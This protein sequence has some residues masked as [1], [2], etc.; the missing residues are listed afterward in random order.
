MKKMAV[1][2]VLACA[3]AFVAV[4]AR[5]TVHV[6][7]FVQRMIAVATPWIAGSAVAMFVLWILLCCCQNGM[8]AR[9]MAKFNRL[10]PFGRFAALAAVLLCTM[11]GGSK[12]RGHGTNATSLHGG[13]ETWV[14]EPGGLRSLPQIEGYVYSGTNDVSSVTNLCFIDLV[15]PS[16]S[17]VAFSVAW[18][19]SWSLPESSL[20]LYAR[21]DLDMGSWERLTAVQVPDGVN[22]VDVEVPLY[23]LPEGGTNR[24]FFTLGTFNDSD[25]DGIPDSDE[26]LMYGTNPNSS[27][28]DGDWML[29]KDE[30][31][32]GSNPC[33]ND[34]DGDGIKD[35]EEVGWI[36]VDPFPDPMDTVNVLTNLT[37]AFL[38]NTQS[39]VDVALTFPCSIS[40]ETFQRMT[41]DP[42]GLIHL[43]GTGGTPNLAARPYNQNINTAS[44]PSN[45]FT[46]AA[47]WAR[48]SL[49]TNEPASSIKI[50]S[51]MLGMCVEFMN[52]RLADAPSPDDN[53]VSFL[54]YLPDQWFPRF[55][56][57][58]ALVGD[59]ADGRN[60]SVGA[61][62]RRGA[63]RRSFCYWQAGRMVDGMMMY[64]EPGYGTDPLVA[65][66][67]SD[68]IDDGEELAL[69]TRPDQPD[70]DGDGMN[71]G[72][73][74]S[75]G[76]DPCTHN[77]ETPRTDDDGTADPDGDGL[78]NAEECEWDT[79]PRGTDANGDGT[80][81][82]YDTDG[83]GV[84]D[85]AEVGQSSDPADAT[86]LGA[87]NSR[88]AVPFYFGD[89]SGSHSEKY[90]LDVKPEPDSGE[91]AQPRAYSWLNAQYGECET[92]TAMLKPGWRYEVTLRHSST[93][94]DAN[95]SPRP[96][97]AYTLRPVT[98]NLPPY[99]VFSD[100]GGLFGVDDTSSTFSGKGKKAQ[101]SV[102][103]FTVNEIWFNHD[104]ESCTLD[105][106]SIRKN[107]RDA[108][109]ALHG[110][111]WLGGETPKNDPVCYAGGVTPKVKVKLKVSPRISSAEFYA[112]KIDS[113]SPLGGL[114]AQNVTFS[115]G[116]SSWV[117]FASDAMIPR[118]VRKVD[119]RWEWKVSKIGSQDVTSFVC[120]TTGPHRVYTTLAIPKPPWK[121]NG[122]DV[123]NIW[124]SAMDFSNSF[125][126]GKNVPQDAMSTITSHLFYDMGFR[127][128]TGNSM[129][130]YWDA[131]GKF[132][133]SNYM[134]GIGNL[135]N[136]HDQAYGV[137]TFAGLV[138]IKAQVTESKP[139]G[140]I[141]TVN[142]V[143]VGPCNNPVYEMAEE[144]E[145]WKDEL[146]NQGQLVT[147]PKTNTVLRTQICSAD[148]TQRSF[149]QTH[150]FVGVYDG[151]IFDACV[152][153]A[154]GTLQINDYMRSV[155]DYSTENEKRLSR[156]W[157]GIQTEASQPAQNYKLK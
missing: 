71:D 64:I 93:D 135:V 1:T 77:D 65:D 155:I 67:D 40:G 126:E 115:D 131:S 92:K 103:R 44:F 125:L 14:E 130:H 5:Q 86:D 94:P 88:V 6:A 24:A 30:I 10:T 104:L 114:S 20:L 68:G 101:V 26:C 81:D 16:A 85:G 23:I 17:A 22:A 150:T 139:F 69:G 47:Y 50:K 90:I 35:G 11:F 157:D 37:S 151:R 107:A 33:S 28:S 21:H 137:A 53:R 46:V 141:N 15:T 75:N 134:A 119:H 56:L 66:S 80:P 32:Q 118:T 7:H 84:N 100:P 140:Y 43:Y 8:F 91:G 120:A 87:P 61:Y 78:T 45:T 142:L 133:L 51:G 82:G 128:D 154:L 121:P 41:I 2:C 4:M 106:V 76:F 36:A 39:C 31:A 25:G 29:D 111:W 34:T 3:M 42:N 9:Q 116:A 127:Y 60:A 143:G 110:E 27:D 89:H 148:E 138:G 57:Q 122:I 152:G 156:Y 144:I 113:S 136:C 105:A 123:N 48:L 112:E 98:N 79:D 99:V 129:S 12:E 18:P 59:M 73:E 95:M 96:D 153:P 55:I 83:D 13:A 109:D 52:M 149:F 147:L 58:Y 97:Y 132:E 108:Y 62:G 54:V 70:T 49:S 146:D 19:M 38:D 102:Y 124:V 72:W 63:Y 145:Y 117:E 74:H